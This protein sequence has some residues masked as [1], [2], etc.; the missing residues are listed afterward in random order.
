VRIAQNK[1]NI[2]K[3]G[4][5]DVVRDWGWAEEYVEGM[6]KLINHE[7]PEDIIFATGVSQSLQVFIETAFDSAKLDWRNYI[8]KE[9]TFV[10]KSEIYFSVGN[11]EKAEKYLG[12]RASTKGKDIAR[13]MYLAATKKID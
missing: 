8:R 6:W 5:T 4:N 12:W 3:L 2:L 9:K 13:R 7:T 11:P 10:R 1:D